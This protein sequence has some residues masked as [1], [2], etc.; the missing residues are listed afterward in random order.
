MIDIIYAI[1]IIIAIFKGLRRGFIVAVFSII[2][3]IIGLAAALKLSALVAVYL[4]KN[5]V[6]AGKWLPFISFALVFIAVVILVN[7]G[8]KL[9]EK[10]FEMAFLGWINRIGGALVYVLLYSIIFSIFLF[11]AEKITLFNKESIQQSITYNF[12][13]PWAPA[14]IGGFGYFIPWFKDSFNQLESFFEGVADKIKH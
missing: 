9:V 7:W 14:I 4:Q 6:I 11:Y 8:G 2:G 3:F 1:L 5:I 13:R 10:T 12:L